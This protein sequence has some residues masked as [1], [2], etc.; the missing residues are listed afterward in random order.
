[1]TTQ[2]TTGLK[3]EWLSAALIALYTLL[4]LGLALLRNDGHFVYALDDPYIHLDLAKQLALSGVYGLNAGEYSSPASSILWPFLI[5]PFAYTPFFVEVPFVIG[6]ICAS[7]SAAVMARMLP[8]SLSALQRIGLS[9]LAALALNLPGLALIGM[10]HGLHV[11]LSLLAAYGVLRSLEANKVP[12]WL[13]AVIILHPLIRYEGVLISAACLG[14]LFW[15]GHYRKTILTGLVL[16][17]PVG[18]FTLFLYTHGLGFFPGSTIVKKLRLEDT[19][20][21]FWAFWLRSMQVGLR[22]PSGMAFTAASLVAP[23]AVLGMVRQWR[24]ARFATVLAIAGVLLGTLIFGRLSTLESPRYDLYATAFVL[25]L[26]LWLLAGQLARLRLTLIA[27]LALFALPGVYASLWGVQPAISAIYQQQYQMGELVK[28]YWHEPIAVND[29]G[30]VG[31]G[32]DAY[33]LD[34]VGI[35]NAEARRRWNLP[36]WA[37]KMVRDRDISLVIVYRSWFPEA[38]R[39]NWTPLGELFRDTRTTMGDPSVLLLTPYPERAD[40]VRAV[41]RDWAKDLPSGARYVEYDAAHPAP[42]DKH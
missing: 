34:L 7:A 36:N 30:I 12:G 2:K 5:A 41:L 24:S 37:D 23:L 1:M 28:H 3:A 22:S 4:Q 32:T 9:F 26:A 29:I 20:G 31:L 13:W 14:I 35:A 42:P 19:A 17:V 40:A 39:V 33:V 38:M 25:P 27:F 6:L 8:V 11:L 10:E 15:Q 18:L 16:C 21:G